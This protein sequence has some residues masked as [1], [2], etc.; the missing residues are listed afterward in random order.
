MILIYYYLK[1]QNNKIL[2]F[3][4]NNLSY[5][6]LSAILHLKASK[7]IKRQRHL[8]KEIR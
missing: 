8:L 2:K 3:H 5:F 1:R 6:E 4:A 7:L